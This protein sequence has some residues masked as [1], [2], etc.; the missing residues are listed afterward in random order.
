MT[1][2]PRDRALL[3][4]VLIVYR[5]KDLCWALIYSSICIFEDIGTIPVAVMPWKLEL[6]PYKVRGIADA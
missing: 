5:G 6:L 3:Y 2:F 1:I 4:A